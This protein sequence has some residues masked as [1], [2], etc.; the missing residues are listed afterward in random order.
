MLSF[1]INESIEIKHPHPKPAFIAGICQFLLL[2][3]VCILRQLDFKGISVSVTDPK[4]FFTFMHV[5]NWS[6]FRVS[7]KFYVMGSVF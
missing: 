3:L 1:S 2:L 5:T 4:S 6:V 7:A